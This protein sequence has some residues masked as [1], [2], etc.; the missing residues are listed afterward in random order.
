MAVSLNT[1]IE[2]ISYQSYGTTRI[3]DFPHT[4]TYLPL[5][6]PIH[7]HLDEVLDLYAS[8][9]ILMGAVTPQIPDREVTIPSNYAHLF[10]EIEVISARHKPVNDQDRQTLQAAQALF[11]TMRGNFENLNLGRDAL[12]RG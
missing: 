1:G 10:R 2:G 3:G 8:D 5:S 12:I 7:S 9:R 4:K 6:A 11:S